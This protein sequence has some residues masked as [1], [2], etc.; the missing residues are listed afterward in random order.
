LRNAL[1]VGSI[2]TVIATVLGTA[3]AISLQL[4]EFR[5]R[6]LLTSLIVSPMV[7]PLVI[8]AA[9]VYFFYLP[10][11]LTDSLF[12]LAL[13]HAALG[14]PFV[15]VTVSATLSGFDRNLVRAAQC[16]G[17]APLTVFFRIVLPLVAPGVISGALFAFVTSF[18]ELVVA[19][20]LTGPA[21]RTL[22]R[23]MFDGIRENISP[24]IL[25]VATL[26]IALAVLLL[27]VAEALR[28]RSL[29]LRGIRE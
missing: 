12:G 22:P 3:A 25:A 15:V 27:L 11:G 26:L 4:A 16:L 20:F 7:V 19:M 21:Q 8:V 13:A 5:G 9:G 2:A 18:D 23:Q 24:T 6:R 1:I 28:R 17:A 10:L 14:A 29:E